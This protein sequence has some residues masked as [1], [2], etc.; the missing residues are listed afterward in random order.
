MGTRSGIAIKEGMHGQLDAT[1]SHE[2][3]RGPMGREGAPLL[4]LMTVDAAPLCGCR[5]SRWE[6]A[7][8]RE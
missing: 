4:L 7:S 5:G 3:T 1:S 8:G 6:E 2:P